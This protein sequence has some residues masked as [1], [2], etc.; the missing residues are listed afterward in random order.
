MSIWAKTLE[1]K[2]VSV[3][4]QDAF[5]MTRTGTNSRRETMKGV[6][7]LVQ[8]KDGST[9]WVTLKDMKNS[10]PVNMA[11]YAVQRRITGNPVFPWWIQ[12]V[13]AKRNHIIGKL[14]SKYWVRTHKFSVKIPKSIQE[15]KAFDEENKNALWWDAICK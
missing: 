8:W 6:E 2:R 14:K 12:Y 7:V 3:K 10:Y 1:G 15:A 4:K 11:E 13:L 9:A 5:I